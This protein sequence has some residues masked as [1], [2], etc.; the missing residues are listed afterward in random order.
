MPEVQPPKGLEPYRQCE[1]RRPS[2][3]RDIRVGDMVLHKPA[4]YF[5]DIVWLKIDIS[6]VGRE[7]TS[8]GGEVW[9]VAE[10]YATKQ[11][12]GSRWAFR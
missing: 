12:V 5:F 7:V 6:R 11:M 2:L 8:A 1:I 4:G 3:A 9:T 10:T